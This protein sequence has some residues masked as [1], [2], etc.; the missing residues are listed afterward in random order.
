[1]PPA[2]TSASN[3]RVDSLDELEADAVIVAVSDTEA[4]R[5]LGLEPAGAGALAD[6]QRPPALRPAAAPPPARRA[7]RLA[8]ALGLRPRRA[9]R[10]RAARRRP[11]PDRRLQRRP[12]P[13]R[14]ARPRASSTRWPTRC[15]SGWAPASSS[16]RA[17]AASRV[18]LSPPAPGRVGFGGRWTP[19]G[20]T[21]TCRR[22]GCVGL[23]RDDG[24]RRPLRRSRRRR[25]V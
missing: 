5:L 24:S 10:P 2:P 4:A 9:H 7:A 23:A 17:S 20:R 8:G 14:G 3:S 6:R 11:V 16:G 21:P 1:M 15:A 19:P 12:R 18:R 13:A 25:A 22:L